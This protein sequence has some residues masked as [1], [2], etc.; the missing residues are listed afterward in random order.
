MEKELEKTTFTI[1]DE[2]GTEREYDVLFTF[3][4]EETK[5]SYIVYTDNTMDKNKNIEVYASTYDP[6]NPNSKLGEVK[7]EKEWKVIETILSS[8]EEEIENK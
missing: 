8:M 5:K 3:D 4:N 1:L 7:T 2:E 6:N